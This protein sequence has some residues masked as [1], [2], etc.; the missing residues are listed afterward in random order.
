M[1]SGHLGA[2]PDAKTAWLVAA[3]EAGHVVVEASQ[4]SWPDEVYLSDDPRADHGGRTIT[5][6]YIAAVLGDGDDIQRERLADA[7]WGGPV[8][9]CLAEGMPLDVD[10][11]VA[12]ALACDDPQADE[13]RLRAMA[14][15]LLPGHAETW[16]EAS[17]R[18]TEVVLLDRWA[19]VVAVADA[20]VKHRRLGRDDLR[21]LL[22]PQSS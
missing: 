16:L 10:E 17:L 7:T 5:R 14:G 20:L 3:H 12:D 4:G 18:R 8:A 9:Q 21:A 11:M 19:D 22:A 2:E 1:T 6:S 13:G 15:H